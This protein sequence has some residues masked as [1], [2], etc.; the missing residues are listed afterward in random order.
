MSK[1]N[2]TE[3]EKKGVPEEFG[4]VVYDFVNDILY[5]FPE[6]KEN[7]NETLME[8]KEGNQE[9]IIKIIDFIKIVYPE[10]IFRLFL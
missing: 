4:K 10:S 1:S 3:E 2:I 5:T 9:N 8:I 7:L 6:F